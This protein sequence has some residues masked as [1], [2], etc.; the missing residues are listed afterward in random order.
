VTVSP[1][2]R[3]VRREAPIAIDRDPAS[4]RGALTLLMLMAQ[5]SRPLFLAR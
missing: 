4:E 1:T 2:R 5:G 3:Q